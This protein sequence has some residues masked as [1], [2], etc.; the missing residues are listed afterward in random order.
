MSER[1]VCYGFS[2]L[3]SLMDVIAI[4]PLLLVYFDLRAIFR[5]AFACLLAP[6]RRCFA[7]TCE[8]ILFS[9]TWMR[10]L[11]PSFAIW[12]PSEALLGKKSRQSTLYLL[13]TASSKIASRGR[14]MEALMLTYLGILQ[15]ALNTVLMGI[16]IYSVAENRWAYRHRQATYIIIPHLNSRY[17]HSH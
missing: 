11:N 3:V 12:M 13:C 14:V 7:K 10:H 15:S 4:S 16:T 8:Q 2:I 17:Y 9:K 5:S 6:L 1:D